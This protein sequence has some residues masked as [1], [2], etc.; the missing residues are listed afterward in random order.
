M[1]FEKRYSFLLVLLRVGFIDARAGVLALLQTVCGGDAADTPAIEAGSR[2]LWE[3]VAANMICGGSKLSSVESL[4]KGRQKHSIRILD[5]SEN[6][7]REAGGRAAATMVMLGENRK[8]QSGSFT[9]RLNVSSH[10]Q[11][12]PV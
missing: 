3:R 7:I 6:Q 2:R 8:Q 10:A 4:T 11:Q 5:V 9:R 12:A 1:S